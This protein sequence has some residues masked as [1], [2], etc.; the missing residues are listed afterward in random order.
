MRTEF[1]AT[2]QRQRLGGR[3][4]TAEDDTV[5]VGIHQRKF[6]NDEDVFHQKVAALGRRVVM[7]DVV[8]VMPVAHVQ[9]HCL[10]SILRIIF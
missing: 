9:F 6:A 7:F 2:L 8:G 3:H 1:L 4:R 5:N 10:S